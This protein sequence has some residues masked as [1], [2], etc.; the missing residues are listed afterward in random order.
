MIKWTAI[1][2]EKQSINITSKKGNKSRQIKLSN[3]N[4]H[5]KQPTR[6]DTKPFTRSQRHFAR[7]LVNEKR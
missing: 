1:N 2:S 7:N 4:Y 3:S 6:D 5:A